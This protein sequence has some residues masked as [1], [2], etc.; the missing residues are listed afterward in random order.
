MSAAYNKKFI[1][2]RI[3]ASTNQFMQN[4]CIWNKNFLLAAITSDS[5]IASTLTLFLHILHK[6]AVTLHPHSNG[7]AVIW[8]PGVQFNVGDFTGFDITETFLNHILN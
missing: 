7:A 6:K 2:A 3:I 4:N 8:A 5:Q 1:V